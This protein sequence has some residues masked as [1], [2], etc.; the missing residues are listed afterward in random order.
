MIK[1]IKLRI[2]HMIVLIWIILKNPLQIL[3]KKS[4]DGS[5]FSIEGYFLIKKRGLRVSRRPLFLMQFCSYALVA[6]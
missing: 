5:I 1:R 3:L 4:V 6:R 2:L